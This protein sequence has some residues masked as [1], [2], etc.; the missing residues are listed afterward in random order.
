[1]AEVM[2]RGYPNH[3]F[4]LNPRNRAVADVNQPALIT[5]KKDEAQQTKSS[6]PADLFSQGVEFVARMRNV[7]RMEAFHNDLQGRLVWNYPRTRFSQ[8]FE[9]PVY[10]SRGI[11]ESRCILRLLCLSICRRHGLGRRATFTGYALP[12]AHASSKIRGDSAVAD[13]D[14]AVRPF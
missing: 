3:F 11:M 9:R 10:C 1:M 2:N 13:R 4:L 8:N 6:T 12:N 7:F 5:R 14:G